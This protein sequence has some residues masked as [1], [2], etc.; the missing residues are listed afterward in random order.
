MFVTEG[1]TAHEHRMPAEE[2]L[3]EVLC[4]AKYISS[5]VRKAQL[6]VSLALVLQSKGFGPEIS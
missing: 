3:Q 1:E 6:Y 4:E 5:M 2:W